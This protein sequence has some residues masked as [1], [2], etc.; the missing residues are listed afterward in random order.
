[1][2]SARS[3]C[4]VAALASL[5]A[6][7]ARMSASEVRRHESKG[8][9]RPIEEVLKADGSAA[10]HVQS[11]IMAS[12]MALMTFAQ[13][14]QQAVMLHKQ[15]TKADL[16]PVNE[17]TKAVVA[18][19][20]LQ[21]M[22]DSHKINTIEFFNAVDRYKDKDG[23]R[24]LALA[25]QQE[26]AANSSAGDLEAHQ[27]L[28][29]HMEDEVTKLYCLQLHTKL[30]LIQ[31]IMKQFRTMTGSYGEIQEKTKPVDGEHEKI[32]EGKSDVDFKVSKG[33]GAAH[34]WANE[35]LLD[36]CKTLEPGSLVMQ[37][38]T[39]LADLV[40]GIEGSGAGILRET[41]T[42]NKIVKAVIQYFQGAI[43]EVDE[44]SEDGAFAEKCGITNEHALDE[45]LSD[46][47]DFQFDFA[48]VDEKNY[49]SDDLGE[50]MLQTS[51]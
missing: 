3:I 46:F 30:S 16:D 42:C 17:A 34:D 35:E 11:M 27:E 22:V 49:D 21:G 8:A 41:S 9:D 33:L 29:N 24:D 48:D 15:L 2:I 45:D 6:D 51:K 43:K 28:M 38:F 1:M 18:A 37:K 44:Y 20:E 31:K 32:T 26:L 12:N 50:S 25:T 4:L 39:F 13:V 23:E 40:T 14:S 47:D 36:V 7:G 5:S 10:A 19:K